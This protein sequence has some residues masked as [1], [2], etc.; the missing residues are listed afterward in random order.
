MIRVDPANVT[1]DNN[2]ATNYGGGMYNVA[3]NPTL[4]NITFSSNASAGSGGGM[5]NFSGS[6]PTLTNVTFS[7]NSA[8]AGGGMHNDSSS[9]SLTNVTFSSN[10]GYDG[11]GIFNNN[12]S[13]PAL[14][15]VTLTGNSAIDMGGGM[16]NN[17]SSSPTLINVILW[18]DTAPT[19]PEIHNEDVPANI[20]YSVVQGA[21]NPRT[22]VWDTS[23]GVDGGGNT[24]ANPLLDSLAYD[25]GFTQTIGLFAGSSAID[26]GNDGSCPATDQRGV[27]R[28]QGAHCDIGAYE[29]TTSLLLL[30]T[31]IDGASLHSLRPNFDWSDYPTASSYQLEVSK[32]NTFT[33]MVLN[34]SITGTSNS[35]YTPTANLSAS[36]LLYWRVRAKVGSTY[37]QWSAV[38][39]FTTGN[40]PSV[41]TLK[42]PS[43]GAKVAGPSPLF[44]WNNS[45]VSGGTVFDHYELQV[46]TDAAFTSPNDT[47]VAGITNSQDNSNVLSGGTTYYWR[48][49]SWNSAGDYSAWSTVRS[50]KIK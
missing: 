17:T 50:V 16:Y 2:S 43:N 44:D 30:I 12:T 27:P 7:G 19:S 40:P 4:T 26:T 14:T 36:A 1:F 34:K 28:P 24:A 33:Q 15:N 18:D 8:G 10:Q 48:V 35:S 46:A 45:T 41:P 42:S 9:P 25:G 23:L 49:R 21:F 39:S 5:D 29:Y 6:N 37:S 32:N 31:P 11:G 38:R 20:S 13:S 3:S 47:S 22:G